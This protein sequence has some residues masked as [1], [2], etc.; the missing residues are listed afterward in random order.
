MSG[1]TDEEDGQIGYDLDPSSSY[2]S[3]SNK[4]GDDFFE[5][6]QPTLPV[7]EFDQKFTV[8]SIPE[9]GEQYLALVRHERS[10]YPSLSVADNVASQATHPNIPIEN[11]KVIKATRAEV[12]SLLLEFD[13]QRTEL[14]GDD[15]ECLKAFD[16]AVK[17][18]DSRQAYELLSKLDAR[19]TAN[20]QSLL[21]SAAIRSKDLRLIVIVA[22]RFGQSDLL[23]IE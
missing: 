12:D 6:K 11:N 18:D 2:S 15:Y 7:A 5:L 23:V 1:Q 21:R 19:L 17:D 13:R 22:C 9:T 8:H 10:K 20:Q 16:K 3:D 4:G 14:A